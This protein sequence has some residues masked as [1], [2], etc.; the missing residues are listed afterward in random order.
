MCPGHA[1]MEVYFF[2]FI[3][4]LGVSYDTAVI[5]LRATAIRV[6]YGGIRTQHVHSL[7]AIFPVLGAQTLCLWT[8]ATFQMMRTN[9]MDAER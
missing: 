1:S 9:Y 6:C 4:F 7:S 3:A 2:H 5:C 8:F